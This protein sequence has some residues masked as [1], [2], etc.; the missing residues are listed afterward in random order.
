ME[1]EFNPNVSNTEP[2]KPAG[3]QD[4]MRRIEENTS[5]TKIEALEAQLR[6]IPLVRAEKVDEAKTLVSDVQ[7]PPEKVL[8]S[9]ATLLALELK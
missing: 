4:A 1:I 6:E 7:Y 5:F 9:I 8:N 2:V 3:R